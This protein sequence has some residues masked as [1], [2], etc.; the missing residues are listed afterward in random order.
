[1]SIK[2]IRKY[3][4]TDGAEFTSYNT[5][6]EHQGNLDVLGGSIS[7]GDEV[8]LSRNVANGSDYLECGII[9]SIRFPVIEFERVGFINEREYAVCSI[10]GM[11]HISSFQIIEINKTPKHLKKLY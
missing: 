1:M 6:F 7:V 10:S 2:S 4:T 11:Y 8:V 5:A 9:K 3:V